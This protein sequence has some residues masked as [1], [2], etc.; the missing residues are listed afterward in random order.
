MS[1]YLSIVKIDPGRLEW[2]GGENRSNLETLM[3]LNTLTA[4]FARS[5]DKYGM[6]LLLV[7]GFA[8]AGA[9]AAAGF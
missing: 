7:L 8:A 4:F 2:L 3:S 5:A 9:T 1:L 6:A